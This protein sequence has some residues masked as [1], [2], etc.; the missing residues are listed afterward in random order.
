MPG[1]TVGHLGYSTTRTLRMRF[2]N[3][4]NSS[5]L[6]SCGITPPTLSRDLSA[7]FNLNGLDAEVRKEYPSLIVRKLCLWS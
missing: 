1:I 5:S 3:T 4:P 7:C 2:P 6:D